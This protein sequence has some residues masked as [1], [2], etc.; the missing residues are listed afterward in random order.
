MKTGF[1]RFQIGLLSA[2]ALPLG[3]LCNTNAHAQPGT[4]LWVQRYGDATFTHGE[5]RSIAVDADGNVI[6]A[7]H[8]AW[9]NYNRDWLILKYSNAGVLLWTNFY[10]GPVNG[11]DEVKAVAVD[12]HG[13]VFVT[14]FSDSFLNFGNDGYPSRDY[15]TIAYSS[16]GVPLW[17]N[18]FGGPVQFESDDEPVAV[19]VDGNGNVV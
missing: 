5:V 1:K 10:D 19:S 4:Q 7:G 12:A 16:A 18:Y 9:P 11:W 14:G 2:A 6:V 13:G 15:T 17:T 8:I 3:I